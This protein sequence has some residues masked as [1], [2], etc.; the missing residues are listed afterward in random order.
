ML[1]PGTDP[2]PR[3]LFCDSQPTIVQPCVDGNNDNKCDNFKDLGWR[4][5]V[6]VGRYLWDVIDSANESSQDDTDMSMASFAGL[7]EAM[8]CLETQLGVE[9]T[10]NEANDDD[11]SC[12]PV[13]DSDL[14]APY[15][16][17]P[18]RDS[19]NVGDIG[20]HVTQSEGSQATEKT[21]NCV[22][23]AFD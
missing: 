19:Y 20:W 7:F 17:E 4:N 5:E 8:S 6:Q 14:V 3:R 9:H 11:P 21:I 13:D 22:D 15:D 18:T 1:R 16:F 12:D 2:R 10:C 23:D